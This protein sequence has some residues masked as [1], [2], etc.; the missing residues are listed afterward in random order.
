MGKQKNALGVVISTQAPDDD[1]PLSMLI[2][3]GLEGLDPSVYAQLHAAFRTPI[4][5]MPMMTTSV[6][7]N[8]AAA[9]PARRAT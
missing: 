2:D 5:T 9:M 4:A 7:R 8:S 6:I 3:D 1:H